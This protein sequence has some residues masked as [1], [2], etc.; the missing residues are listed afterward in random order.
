MPDETTI[1]AEFERA[2]MNAV[3][4]TDDYFAMPTDDPHREGLW[5]DVA[6]ETERARV[7]LERLLGQPDDAA[8]A[9]TTEARVLVLA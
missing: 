5:R 7:L 8:E 6:S 2:R 1:H 9:H 4:L 3:A